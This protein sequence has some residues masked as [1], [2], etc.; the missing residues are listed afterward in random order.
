MKQLKGV[1]MKTDNVPGYDI[2]KAAKTGDDEWL[3]QNDR[4][5]RT[6]EQ[7][8]ELIPELT[9]KSLKDIRKA[10]DKFQMKATPYYLGLVNRNNIPNDPI[11]KMAVPSTRE[12]KVLPSELADPIGDTNKSLNNQPVPM[13]THRYP[14]RVLLYPTPM[15]G[16]YCR[17]CF[18][19][20]LAGK[21]EFVPKPDGL[22][23]ALKYIAE[24]REIH[25]VILTGGDPLLT[26]DE[27]LFELLDSIKKIRH[28]RTIRIH[29][30]MPVVNP[31]RLTSSLAKGLGQF[32]P[33]WLVTHFNHANEITRLTA[34][35]IDRLLKA[36]IPVLNQGVL[37]KGVNDNAE[38]L[39]ELGWKLIETN[40]K[41]Y[42]LH[43]LDR[44]RGISHF[45][46]G[47]KRGLRILKELRGTMPGYAIPDY[48]LDIPRG[49]GKVPLQYHY[50]STDDEGRIYAETPEGDYRLYPD[51]APED[52]EAPSDIPTL[53]PFSAYP[54]EKE[55][56]DKL[57]K[58]IEIKKAKAEEKKKSAG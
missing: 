42:Y 29:S 16:T 26:M 24:H 32:R 38:S 19:R 20:R 41:P 1:S 25:E 52:P 14:D 49:Y 8:C 28:I 27:Q 7:L 23:Q 31:Y 57:E 22:R 18:R 40:I 35:G 56:E 10:C 54:D 55:L 30:R 45:R 11:W 48:I 47:V 21:D 46:V 34:K 58:I 6:P 53:S 51:T 50:L 2:Q 15:C 13:L 44:A 4:A 5:I 12:L 33:L 43:H 39:R 17:H 3:R 9:F 37:L 36:G